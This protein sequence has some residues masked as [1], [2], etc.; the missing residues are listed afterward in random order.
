MYNLYAGYVS[1]EFIE[2]KGVI[3]FNITNQKEPKINT[4]IWKYDEYMLFRELEELFL[5]SDFLPKACQQSPTYR[6]G[7]D[8]KIMIHDN[9]CQNK[10]KPSNYIW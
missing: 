8:A 9:C 6:K 5:C 7:V 10:K 1:T 2:E 4:V 3:V